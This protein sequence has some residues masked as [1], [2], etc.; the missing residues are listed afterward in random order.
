MSKINLILAT[1]F[2]VMIFGTAQAQD[3]EYVTDENLRRYAIME[4][5][6]DDMKSEISVVL[7]DMIKNQDGFDGKRY[8]ELKSGSGEPASDFENKIMDQ[9]NNMVDE[10]K[11]AIGDVVKILATKMLPDGGKAYNAIKSKLASDE[12]VKTKYAAIKAEVS[13]EAAE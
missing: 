13:G 11:E 4:E 8:S 6:I 9:I 12:E 3:D 7:N 2:T 5:V 1:L 10:R